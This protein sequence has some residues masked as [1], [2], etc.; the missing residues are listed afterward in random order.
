MNV[1][2]GDDHPR[3]PLGALPP[4][5]H[6]FQVLLMVA[7]VVIGLSA[8]AL[9]PPGSV[10]ALLPD[11]GRYLWATVTL[12]GGGGTIVASALRDRAYGLLVE[13]ITLGL[14]TVAAPIYAFAVARLAARGPDVPAGGLV[15]HLTGPTLPGWVSGIPPAMI[16]IGIGVAAGWRIVHVGREL[17]MLRDYLATHHITDEE[18]EA[19]RR[20]RP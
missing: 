17:G 3:D 14:L 2:T 15:T 10:N 8:V 16:F 7:L 11:F 9:S 19:R 6:P 5:R 18:I 20:E 1:H 13:R 12:V 4:S